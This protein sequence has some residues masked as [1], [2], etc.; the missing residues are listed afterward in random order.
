MSIQE[1]IACMRR[2]AATGFSADQ[3]MERQVKREDKALEETISEFTQT[4]LQRQAEGHVQLS[5]ALD[6]VK[7]VCHFE[8]KPTQNSPVTGEVSLMQSTVAVLQRHLQGQKEALQTI[9]ENRERMASQLE[10]LQTTLHHSAGKYSITD[11]FILPAAQAFATL[12]GVRHRA[13]G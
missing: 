2:L 12:Q 3:L 13:Q 11:D 9:Q 10:G 7:K 8:L 1:R 4:L 5:T 6:Q